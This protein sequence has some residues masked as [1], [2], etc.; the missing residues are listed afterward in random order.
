MLGVD[1]SY[2]AF[3]PQVENKSDMIATSNLD[4]D[5]LCISHSSG[6]MVDFSLASECAGGLVSLVRIMY[7]CIADLLC[8][9]RHSWSF[10][11]HSPL[12]TP[13][14]VRPC[15]RVPARTARMYVLFPKVPSL[16][17]NSWLTMTNRV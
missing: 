11:V 6:F 17:V 2:V 12:A 4:A 13:S 16:T 10:I 9:L 14:S 1:T 15:R 3:Q 8:T 7:I 5:L